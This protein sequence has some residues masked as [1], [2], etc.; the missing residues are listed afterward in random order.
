MSAA[1]KI[2]IVGGGIVGLTAATALRQRGFA[3]ELVEIKHDSSKQVG[4]GLTIVPN[5]LRALATIGVAK[6]CIAAGM[7]SHRLASFTTDGSPIERSHAGNQTGEP[8]YPSVGIGR[9]AFHGLLAEAALAEGCTTR[10]GVTVRELK[11]DGDSV[12]VIFTDGD[13]ASYD[14]VVGA[15]GIHSEMRVRL[16]PGVEPALT[17]HAVWRA[18]TARPQEVLCSHLY[19]GGRHGVVGFCP[20]SQSLGYVYVVQ[21]AEPGAQFDRSLMHK[22]LREQ[23]EGYG[24][25]IPGIAG[26]LDDPETVNYQP[27]ERLIAPAPWYQGRTVIIGDAVHAGP[28]VLAQG[29]AMGIEDAVVLAEEL[30]RHERIEVALTR[31]MERRFHRA[32]I[33]TEASVALCNW[34]IDPQSEADIGAI[35]GRA[36][37]EL[38]RPI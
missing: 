4:V 37:A 7:P 21:R 15:D 18:P 26:R 22:I 20:I 1:Q 38:A 5:A 23:L 33:V 36:Q 32:R 35:V 8:E 11:D 12:S 6:A 14:L 3:V 29:A 10:F 27:I 19:F 34:Q 25:I 17:G 13:S 2:L 30:D 16:F 24:G 31:F 28:P 9:A